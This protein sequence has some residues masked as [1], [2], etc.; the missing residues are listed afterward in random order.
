MNILVIGSGAREHALAW[1]LCQ[2]RR[3]PKIFALPGNDGIRP[4]AE[5]V[6]IDWRHV[7][8]VARFAV[9]KR[10][11]LVV[12][13]PDDALALGLTDALQRRGIPVF[14]PTRAAAEIEWSKT[15]A[16]ELMLEQGIPTASYTVLPDSR[17]VLRYF[18]H[19]KLPAVIKLDG[20]AHGKGV[21][22]CKTLED[23]KSCLEKIRTSARFQ[24][25]AS[26]I[27]IEEYLEGREVSIH[28]LCD[29]KTSLLFPPARD[30]KQLY[31]GGPN[32]GGMG[33]YVPAEDFCP[34]SMLF[35]QKKIVEPALAALRER[36]RP[37]CGLLYPGLMITDQG[38]MALEY[39]AR[40]GDPEAQ[41][42]MRL[43]KSDLVELMEACV[44][45][46]LAQ[47]KLEWHPGYVVCVVLASRGY[48][49]SENIETGKL[50]T[51]LD[52]AKKVPGVKIFCAGVRRGMGSLYTAGGRVL[53]VTA[54]GDTLKQAR[55]RANEAVSLVS[56]DGVQRHPEIAKEG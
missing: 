32:T 54:I 46:N 17:F 30:Y 20:L 27:I 38:P 50:I 35:V 36:D 5:R 12:I 19:N 43:L 26:K 51:G 42:Y 13:G 29:G 15:Y 24:A 31:R 37:F 55:E 4:L 23:V 53:S 11:D 44:T 9:S 49:I 45:G 25:A 39:N 8:T 52:E 18:R 22:I 47:Q 33:G 6:L 21:W 16:K 1:K 7:E 28:A 34:F 56:F 3:M 48:G 2:S 10:I 41:L 40:F 14:G